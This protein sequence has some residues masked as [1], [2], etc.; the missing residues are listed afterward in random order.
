MAAERLPFD[1]EAIPGDSF[2]KFA[3]MST[4]ETED[5]YLYVRC[6]AI[7]SRVNKNNDGWPSAELAKSYKSF[8]G[9]PIFV[10]HNNDN[11][12]RARGVIVDSRLHVED[13]E[14][15]ASFDPYYAS[16]PDNHRPPTW[17]ELLLEVDAKTFPKLAQAVRKGQVDAVSMGANIETSVCSVCEHTAKTPIEYC[18]HVS[19]KGAEF[20]VTSA[21]GE[22][23]MKKAYEDCHD[24][25]FFEI[26]FVFDPA[27]PTALISEKSDK[28]MSKKTAGEPNVVMDPEQ[29]AA[30]RGWLAEL[31][32]SN[33]GLEPEDIDPQDNTG[34][35]VFSD[36][37]IL[38]NIKRYYDGGVMAFLRD[39]WDGAFAVDI[40]D[41]DAL[42]VGNPAPGLNSLG[43]KKKAKNCKCWE[44]YER[45]PG[46]RACSPGSCRKCDDHR[47][48]KK[49]K[50]SELIEKES[51]LQVTTPQDANDHRQLNH[52]P[53]SE[54]I[55]SPADVDTLKQDQGG[56]E[57][58]CP[59]CHSDSLMNDAQGMMK[60]P[61]CSWVQPP[62]PLDNPD[63]SLHLEV[64]VD[65]S[66]DQELVDQQEDPQVTFFNA[67]SKTIINEMKWEVVSNYTII[68]LDKLARNCPKC[69]NEMQKSESKIE[70]CPDCDFGTW[71]PKEGATLPQKKVLNP[72]FVT[73]TEDPQNAKVIS[74]QK[75]PVTSSTEKVHMENN[76]KRL[77]IA[78]S[79]AD[80]FVQLGLV[81]E[82]RKLAF[83]A[84]LEEETNEALDARKATIA[85]V[86]E[87]GIS[88]P[89]SKVAGLSR[90]PKLA[91]FRGESP[92]NL[93]DVPFE[94]IFM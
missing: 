18:S 20:E 81:E 43:S 27:D 61:S 67:Q 11:P 30:A 29:T 2:N 50:S 13:E 45:V 75:Q 60:C 62:H 83:V 16:A 87:A 38:A 28:R 56:Q 79:L 51:L 65:K 90:V 82:D 52:V 21:N 71:E 80:E 6:R 22:K 86:K 66:N 46:T 1:I 35:S 8:I 84:E 47:D 85:L 74:D 76:E 73:K 7:S 23:M 63:L 5:G 48:K 44:G 12:E 58:Q 72:S 78:F 4:Q 37:D 3:A 92:M 41:L 14:K 70:K 15:T 91:G 36:Q 77:L 17:I 93:D 68:S 59:N 34:E 94:S 88:R 25:T 64:D 31:D 33:A 26:S 42:P 40:S 54:M 10:D 39:W 57:A 55:S 69:G 49:K 53:Q 19:S 24:I 9:R 89:V 32:W